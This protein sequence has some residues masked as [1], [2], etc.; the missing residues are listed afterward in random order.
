MGQQKLWSGRCFPSGY[1][2]GAYKIA[3][4]DGAA[5]IS[6]DSAVASAE[7]SFCNASA[8]SP[9]SAGPSF[10]CTS[11]SCSGAGNKW[12]INCPIFSGGL[13]SFHSPFWKVL[14]SVDVSIWG[15]LRFLAE[16]PTVWKVV[17]SS[18]LHFWCF[19]IG[20]SMVP[21]VPYCQIKDL[22][23]NKLNCPIFFS[24]LVNFQFVW[25]RIVSHEAVFK[26]HAQRNLLFLMTFPF[27]PSKRHVFFSYMVLPCPT[28]FHPFRSRAGRRFHG[29]S[30]FLPEHGR[31]HPVG[32]TGWHFLGSSFGNTQLGTVHLSS[33]LVWHVL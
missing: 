26:L 24:N 13:W 10:T 31:E 2:F 3:V 18:S 27:Y 30:Q 5:T 21:M 14:S 11:N 17:H 28:T 9:L 23:S 1:P 20:C 8:A 7:A 6:N 33:G 22:I 16:K 25:S 15:I 12:V 19:R 4:G 29:M 32:W